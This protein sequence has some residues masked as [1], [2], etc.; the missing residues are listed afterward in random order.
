MREHIFEDRRQAGRELAVQLARRACQDPVVLAL[1]RGGV[2]VADEIA[3]RLSAPLDVVLVRK[4]G[5]PGQPELAVG[6]VVDG[7][8]REI[9]LN[10]AIVAELDISPEYIAA[11]AARELE[12]IERRRQLWLGGKP[13]PSLAGR[14]VIVVDDGI[15]TGATMRAALV[16]VRRR[17]PARLIVAVPVAP[18]SV[19]RAMRALADEVVCLMEPESFGAIGYFYVDFTQVEDREV[20]AILAGHAHLS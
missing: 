7:A 9:V 16:A 13:Y 2:P 18:P 6:A 12:T 14:T 11:T 17:N 8:A 10:D 3:R 19:A 20:S 4:I 5:A 1:P 15:A